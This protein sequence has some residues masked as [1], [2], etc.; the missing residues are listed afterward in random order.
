MDKAG[1]LGLFREDV[2]AFFKLAY[3][4]HHAESFKQFGGTKLH[5]DPRS[6]QTAAGPARADKPERRLKQPNITLKAAR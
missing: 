2:N 6:V 3:R 1:H 5:R 4:P